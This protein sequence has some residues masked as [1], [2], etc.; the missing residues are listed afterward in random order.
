MPYGMKLQ[1]YFDPLILA[2]RATSAIEA[3]TVRKRTKWLNTRLTTLAE[4]W[5]AGTHQR[6]AVGRRWVGLSRPPTGFRHL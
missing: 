4:E 3:L 2:L 1:P 5:L 6:K